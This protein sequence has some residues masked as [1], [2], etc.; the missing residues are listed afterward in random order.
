MT[1]KYQDLE[2]QD[3]SL[4]AD[5]K[6]KGNESKQFN[7]SPPQVGYELIPPDGTVPKA[8]LLQKLNAGILKMLNEAGSKYTGETNDQGQ[9]HGGG[10][11]VYIDGSNYQG[12][13]RNGKREG[14][15]EFTNKDGT[16]YKGQ[17][18]NDM[19]NGDGKLIQADGAIIKTTWLND[20]KNGQGLI[21]SKDG[22]TSECEY[23]NDI[24]VQKQDQ[25][26]DCSNLAP[27]NFILGCTVIA[28][29]YYISEGDYKPKNKWDII[30]FEIFFCLVYLF[31]CAVCKTNA[32]LSDVIR[33]H[34]SKGIIDD[35]KAKAPRIEMEIENYHYELYHRRRGLSYE[36]RVS[37]RFFR[38]LKYAEY[39]D[40]SAD[41]SSVEHIKNYKLTR[42]DIQ[43][44]I[45]YSAQASQSK[46]CQSYDFKKEK[47]SDTHYEFNLKNHL[48]G[49]RQS[50]LVHNGS[51][52]ESLPWY[53]SK[54]IYWITHLLFI[55]WIFRIF[56]VSN[57]QRVKF[58]IDKVILK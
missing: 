14:Y 28:L 23:F 54:T 50:I 35:L 10:K 20:K 6:F 29:G 27:L 24:L 47:V 7:E 39:M 9:K 16:V 18:S 55:G 42:L 33:S 5:A 36:K 51:H 40:Q 56:F 22:K 21:T 30:G 11:L 34:E 38:D 37:S 4:K 46:E 45:Q 8:V 43:L 52:A 19:K 44:D 49:F 58:T 1:Q 32:Y 53:T 3:M 12:A 17:W 41:A 31:E 2:M 13:W 25:N 57:S 15:G 48:E 26:P